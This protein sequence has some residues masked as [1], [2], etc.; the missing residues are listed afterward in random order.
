VRAPAH[1]SDRWKTVLRHAPALLGLLL[2]V[3]AV[4]VVQR[5]FRSLKIEDIRRSLEAIPHRA[6]AGAFL[7]TL[8]AYGILTFYDRLG[9]IYAGRVVSYARVAF[10]SFC[11]YALSHNLGFAAVSGAAV[12]YRL[13]DHW[14][15]PPAQIAKVIAFCSLTYGLG[16]MAL[17]GCILFIEPG[18]LPF[19]GERVPHVAMYVLG[20]VLFAIDIAYV[21]A[22]GT[23]G[24]IRLFGHET[25]LPSWR[26]AILQVLLATADVAV[27]AAI[28]YTLLPAAHGLNYLRFVGIYLASYTAGLAATVPGGLGVFDGAILLGLAPYLDAPPV[29]GAI[30]VFR[31]Y[32]YIIPLFLAGGLF[33]GNE[34]MLRGRLLLRRGG[35]TPIGRISE[36]DFAVAAAGGAVALCGFLLLSLGVLEQRPDFS[37]IDPDFAEV[38]ASAGQFVPSLIGAAL[39]VLAVALSQ[40]VNLAWGS[41]IALLLL[42]AVFTVAQGE[43]IWIPSVLLL[44]SLLVA[45]YRS[46]FY[47]HAR[48]VSTPLQPATALPLLTLVVCV[49]VLAAF[50][51]HV[52]WLSDNSWWEVILSPDVPN[53]LRASV[54]L[55]VAL[56]LLAMWRL[57]RPRRVSWAPWQGPQRLRY[58]SL[59]A[60]PPDQADGVVWGE[61]DRAAIPF[62]RLGRTL[63][64]LGD[65]AGADSDRISAV[66]RFR[67]LAQQEGRSPAVWRAGRGLLGVYADLGL[68]ALPLGRDGLPRDGVEDLGA[69]EGEAFLVC[70]AE[71]DPSALARA[72]AGA[73]SAP[74]HHAGD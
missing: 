58:A 15:L 30:L 18:A 60:D 61:A 27:T 69:A 57:L 33:A 17:A 11:A 49:L 43:P 71:R 53:S 34:I 68:S 37:W 36:P 22:A 66:W 46:A 47:R 7:W 74:R 55:T 72:L 40:R 21:T 3:G 42:G 24:R 13:Y 19:V 67:D 26:M 48:L 41:T 9:T 73:Q 28:F 50:E 65:P 51:R 44:A 54:G 1:D 38:A 56:A 5:E 52:R 29:I 45:P 10:A 14:G 4:F 32:Y 8:A 25:Q 64:A 6:L 31:L 70:A 35:V 59:G 23:L 39:I 12:R 62:R 63:V 2:L 20:A 16:G